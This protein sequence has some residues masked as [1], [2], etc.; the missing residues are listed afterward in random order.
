MLWAVVCGENK[1]IDLLSKNSTFSLKCFLEDYKDRNKKFN[2]WTKVAE[3]LQSEI[4]QVTVTF[5]GLQRRRNSSLRKHPERHIGI[6]SNFEKRL[7]LLYAEVMTN[8]V[9][10]RIRV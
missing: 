7:S 10:F 2:K 5:S 9:I 6:F 1:T 4:A 3:T 8:V